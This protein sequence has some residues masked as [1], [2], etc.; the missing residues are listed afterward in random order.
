MSLANDIRVVRDRTLAELHAQYDYYLDTI[1]VWEIARRAI[2]AGDPF[3]IRNEPTGTVVTPKSLLSRQREYISRHLAEATFQQFIGTLETFLFDLLRLWLLAHPG[4][5]YGRKLD[6]R[7]VVEAG[8]LESVGLLV[9]NRELNELLYKRPTEWF[10]YLEDRLKLG[11]PD[12]ATVAL[13]AEAKATRDALAHSAGVAGKQYLFK[14]GPLARHA[15]GERVD[16][17]EP[18][19]RAAWLALCEMVAAVGDAAVAKAA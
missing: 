10:A 1:T 15:L 3:Q 18:Y 11:V 2:T 16:V 7:E 13:F 14:A 19:H 6:Y 8:D 5:L 12:A 17:S 9:A 4:N